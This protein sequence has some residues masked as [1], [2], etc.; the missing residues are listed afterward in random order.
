MTLVVAIGVMFSTFLSGTVAMLGTLGCI[1]LGF[2]TGDISNLFKSVIENDRKLVA[3]GGPIES[4]VRL[5]TQK[6]ITV[7]YDPSPIVNVMLVVD[8]IFMYVMKAFTDVVPD[9]SK[10]NNVNF[11]AN[12]F[13]VPGDLI[14]QQGTMLLGYVLGAFLAGFLFLRMREVAR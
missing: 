10:F 5:I 2:F 8:K 12:G 14:W 9:F 3:G 13:N 1:V 4:F 7:E 6:T 11:V